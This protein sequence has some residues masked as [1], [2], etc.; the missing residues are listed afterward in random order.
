MQEGT[1]NRI[2]PINESDGAIARALEDAHLPSLLAAMVQVTG[3]AE[4]LTGDIKPA[5]DFFGDGQ[6]GLSD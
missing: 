6:G 2:E 1:A 5:Y 4:P 3:D